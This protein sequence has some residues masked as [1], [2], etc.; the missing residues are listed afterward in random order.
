[1][2]I[3]A[4]HCC[5]STTGRAVTHHEAPAVSAAHAH[6]FRLQSHPNEAVTKRRIPRRQPETAPMSSVAERDEPMT[7][8][9]NSESAPSCFVCV[10]CRST[11][12][13]EQNNPLFADD[14]PG[15]PF[16]DPTQ[17]PVPPEAQR[18]YILIT[19]NTRGS[20]SGSDN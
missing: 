18:L 2:A 19:R 17:R 20:A 6:L 10:R 1:M 5:Y 16:I 14:I 7:Q 8:E 3:P 15:M 11:L 9:P 13:E 4:S 12:V